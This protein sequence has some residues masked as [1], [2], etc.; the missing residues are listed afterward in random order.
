MRV[1]Q[2]VHSHDAYD[3][4]SSLTKASVCTKPWLTLVIF[5]HQ[6]FCVYES[7]EAL[8]MEDAPWY[9]YVY[10]NSASSGIQ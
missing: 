9:D 8:P 7:C 1:I 3:L 5:A 2:C 10:F 4:S 6:S